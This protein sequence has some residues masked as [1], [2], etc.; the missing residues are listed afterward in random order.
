MTRC[1]WEEAERVITDPTAS[2]KAG[3]VPA[4]KITGRFL[5]CKKYW[6]WPIWWKMESMS[7]M[8]TSVHFFIL[9]LQRAGVKEH[10]GVLGE[11]EIFPF[12]L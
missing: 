3:L 7:S 11:G 12:G 2:S 1:L 8:F 6:I 10:G 9:G 5:Y 4:R